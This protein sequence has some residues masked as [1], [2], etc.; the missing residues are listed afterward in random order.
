MN[1]V[2]HFSLR[3]G[4]IPIC[5]VELSLDV[6][7]EVEEEG[8]VVE[9]SGEAALNANNGCCVFLV[10]ADFTC[11]LCDLLVGIVVV[12]LVVLDGCCVDGCCD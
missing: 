8:L 5:E 11:F 7:P 9:E 2:I 12:F 1:L 6:P 3:F 10:L 4:R